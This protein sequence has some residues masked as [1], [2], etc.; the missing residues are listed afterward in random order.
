[1]RGAPRLAKRLISRDGG[2]SRAAKG[3]DCKSAGLRLRRFES[4]LPHH[5]KKAP[6]FLF[7]LSHSLPHL[8]LRCGNRCSLLVRF[9]QLAHSTASQPRTVSAARSFRRACR[10][11][12]A[13]AVCRSCDTSGSARSPKLIAETFFR[14][15][16]AVLAGDKSKVAARSRPGRRVELGQSL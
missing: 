16:S 6:L 11:N 15:R 13:N 1:M 4:Y 14:H 8:S 2:V 7:A 10:C 5:H 12:F 9:P 3:A